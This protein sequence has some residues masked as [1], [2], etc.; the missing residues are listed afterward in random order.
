MAMKEGARVK[1]IRHNREERAVVIGPCP[2]LL[3]SHVRIEV[4]SGFD[5]GQKWWFPKS[6]LLVARL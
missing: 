4:K 2:F 5:R 6:S 1:F 3:D